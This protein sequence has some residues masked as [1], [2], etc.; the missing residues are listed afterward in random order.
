VYVADG[1][2]NGRIQKFDPSGRLLEIIDIPA[3]VSANPVDLDV[4]RQGNVYVADNGNPEAVYVF[5]PGDTCA[6][7]K[8]K[9]KKAKKKKRA[10]CG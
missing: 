1:E 3:F 6:K 8:K 10:A 4:D 7:A 2:G 9:L 5:R